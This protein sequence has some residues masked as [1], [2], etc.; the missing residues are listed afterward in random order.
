MAQL[1]LVVAHGA[2]RFAA[3]DGD[4]GVAGACR[5]ETLDLLDRH[6]QI[7]VGQEDPRAERGESAGAHRGA[8]AAHRF[9]EHAH[10]MARARPPVGR[11]RRCRRCWR[12][13]PPESPPERSGPRR[14]SAREAASAAGARTR[15][16]PGSRCSRKGAGADI[17]DTRVRAAYEFPRSRGRSSGP[18]RGGRATGRG[19]CPRCATGCALRYSGSTDVGQ[20]ESPPHP[21]GSA[22]PADRGRWERYRAP[23]PG[24]GGAPARSGPPQARRMPGGPWRCWVK[25]S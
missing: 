23:R 17:T 8:L 9:V 15:C 22:G 21:W 20:K 6:R 18:G 3:G 1:R 7:G 5:Q 2:R 11:S 12:C 13:R 19:R 16:T 10:G 14:T 4:V 25:K 24:R